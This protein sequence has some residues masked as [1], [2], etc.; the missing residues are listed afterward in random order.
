MRHLF[1]HGV[2]VTGLAFRINGNQLLTPEGYQDATVSSIGTT[3]PDSVRWT[4]CTFLTG[5]VDAN[6]K[7]DA[8][9][10]IFLVNYVFKSG[11]PPQCR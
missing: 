8:S 10:I 3:L 6:Q 11:S 1:E 5:D 7:F 4:A 2:L 9:D